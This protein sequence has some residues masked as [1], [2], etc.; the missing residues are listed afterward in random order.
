VAV[1]FSYLTDFPRRSLDEAD[2][3][4]CETYL[5]FALPPDFRAFL[6]AHDGPVPDPAW[7]PV[8]DTASGG[9]KWLGPVAD[10]KSVMRCARDR[11]GRTRGNDIESYT[12]SSR[13]GQKL[14]RHFAVIGGMM[15]QPSLLLISTAPATYGSI[16]AWHVGEKR[17]RPDQVVRVAGSFTEFLGSL[18]EPPEDVAAGFRR[19]LE[20]KRTARRAGTEQRPPAGEYGGPEAR[21]WLRRNRH[22]TPLA[23]NHFPDAAAAR[24][25]VDG[26]Y[27]AGAAKVIVPGSSI[28]DA[29]DDGPYAD[30]LVVF[31]P[32][33][34]VAR[35]LV[36]QYCQRGLDQTEAFDANDQNP[37][38][39]WWT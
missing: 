21:R 10:F 12:Y 19:M 15:T 31:L 27:A 39:L 16:F 7:V 14:P 29:D 4:E 9:T 1:A 11:G 18:A 23:A 24:D 20:Q 37:I 32:A 36:C 38:F 2:V 3:V 28:R 33:D 22:P 25:F 13:E 35:A 17:F 26:L 30:A 6:L 8:P 34:A 5:G